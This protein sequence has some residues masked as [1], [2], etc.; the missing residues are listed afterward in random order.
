MCPAPSLI[1][2]RPYLHVS[3]PV[4]EKQPLRTFSRDRRLHGPFGRYGRSVTGRHV[5][6][7]P[8]CL[9]Q[10]HC[11]PVCILFS[12]VLSRVRVL[13]PISIGVAAPIAG[14]PILNTCSNQ[15]STSCR[16][17]H[18]VAQGPSEQTVLFSTINFEGLLVHVQR[19]RPQTHV[20][21][22]RQHHPILR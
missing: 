13:L 16:A 12:S 20:L 22:R 9:S 5:W 1:K 15:R 17:E 8:H 11:F 14:S 7:K 4:T 3:C 2:I 18:S 10:F 19:L 21:L 6:F